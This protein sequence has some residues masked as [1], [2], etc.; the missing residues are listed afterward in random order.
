MKFTG[1]ETRSLSVILSDCEQWWLNLAFHIHRH[2]D[3]A[4]FPFMSLALCE[5]SKSA[6]QQ[7]I[8]VKE[9]KVEET[10]LF[11]RQHQD[12]VMMDAASHMLVSLGEMVFLLEVCSFWLLVFCSSGQM[13]DVACL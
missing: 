4:C 12:E 8:T 3:G 5:K 10:V 1:K 13:S 9:E 11:L 2:V 6:T 7:Y